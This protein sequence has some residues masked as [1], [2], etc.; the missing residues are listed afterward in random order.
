[1]A[2]QQEIIFGVPQMLPLSPGTEDDLG[3][4][5]FNVHGSSE[6]AWGLE[7]GEPLPPPFSGSLTT[8][9]SPYP[10]P[11]TS[12]TEPD[13]VLPGLRAPGGSSAPFS[14]PVPHLFSSWP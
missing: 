14:L 10:H 12:V 7:G 3:Q 2:G 11:V 8:S 5:S 4:H 1:M 6:E 13:S 9:A